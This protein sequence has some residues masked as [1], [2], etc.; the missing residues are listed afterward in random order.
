MFLFCPFHSDDAF[1]AL[2][3]EVKAELSLSALVFDIVGVITAF[4]RSEEYMSRPLLVNS[5]IASLFYPF[6]V[7]T[8]P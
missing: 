1:C 5:L 2:L 4:P 7:S 8:V 6:F 3:P